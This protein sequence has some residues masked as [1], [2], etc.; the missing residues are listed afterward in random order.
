MKNCYPPYAENLVYSC[1][2]ANDNM[3]K[4]YIS[5]LMC[6]AV[7][8][9]LFLYLCYFGPGHLTLLKGRRMEPHF[10]EGSKVE[11]S[12]WH[13]PKERGVCLNCCLCVEQAR[14]VISRAV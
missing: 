2:G 7:L 10:V 12:P 13:A 9:L 5:S 4:F 14:T 11:T 6:D 8:R 1:A 3:T